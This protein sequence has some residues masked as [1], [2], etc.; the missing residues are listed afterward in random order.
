VVGLFLVGNFDVLTVKL[1]GVQ[2][3]KKIYIIKIFREFDVR[4]VS[5]VRDKI[6]KV[7]CLG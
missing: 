3:N 4:S 6:K 2:T 1:V 5:K 7:D